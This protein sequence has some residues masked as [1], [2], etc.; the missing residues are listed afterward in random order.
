VDK[1]PPNGCPPDPGSDELAALRAERDRLVCERNLLQTE[2]AAYRCGWPPGHFYSP[3][4]SVAEIKQ[5]EKRIF[6]GFGPTLAGIDLNAAGQIQLWH[7]LARYYPEQPFAAQKLP[8]L[9]YCF[10][11]PNFTYGEALVLFCL[12][13]WLRPR[14]IIE[15]GSG[16]SSCA[17]LDTNARFFANGIHCAFID[18]HPELLHSLVGEANRTQAEFVRSRVQDV[19]LAR[20]AELEERDIIFVDSSHVSKVHSDVNWIVFEILP[21]LRPGVFV[22]FH[23]VCYPFEYPREWIYRGRAW[24]EAYLIRAFLLYNRAFRI[25]V[26]NSYLALFHQELLAETMPLCLRNP[27]T[28]LWL[29]KTT[30]AGPVRPAPA[31]SRTSIGSTRH[32]MK[33]G[34]AAP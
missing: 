24:N 12:L 1:S 5:E 14:R 21:V 32:R 2:L 30:I 3:V 23:D 9:N 26:F 16:Y 15:I 34:E 27:G 10:D 29:E 17:L 11:N 7:E 8:G 20:F 4:P 33:P 28:S 19:D 25:R 22:H 31:P 18:P 13:R 6:E